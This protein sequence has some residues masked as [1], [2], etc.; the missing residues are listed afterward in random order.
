[1]SERETQLQWWVARQKG[2]GALGL[3]RCL[4]LPQSYRVGQEVS[5]LPHCYQ[6]QPSAGVASAHATTILAFLGLGLHL[7]FGHKLV[8]DDLKLLQSVPC[9]HPAVT[10]AGFTPGQLSR[11]RSIPR[12][13]CLC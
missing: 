9:W 1:M 13:L 6:N 4:S 12:R 8:C 2:R 10:A 5:T 3:G 11:A 7:N